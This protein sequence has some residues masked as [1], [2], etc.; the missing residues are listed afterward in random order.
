M[1]AESGV[2]DVMYCLLALLSYLCLIN[3]VVHKVLYNFYL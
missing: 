2:K 1:D 3:T